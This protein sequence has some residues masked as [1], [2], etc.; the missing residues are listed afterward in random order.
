[1]ILELHDCNAHSF[2]QAHLGICA[3]DLLNESHKIFENGRR[4]WHE[5]RRREFVRI[6]NIAQLSS[7]GNANHKVVQGVLFVEEVLENQVDSVPV[8]FAW[9][10]WNPL[11]EN[12][13]NSPSN[14]FILLVLNLDF[15][16]H[17]SLQKSIE[18]Q[19]LLQ[20]GRGQADC[21]I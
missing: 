15:G 17:R 4:K 1:M 9:L 18:V 6:E 20:T 11:A 13:G 3:L 7:G 2:Q 19:M 10:H 8:H 12:D 16:N 14:N 21:R 5:F